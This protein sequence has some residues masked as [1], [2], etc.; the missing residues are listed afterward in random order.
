MLAIIGAHHVVCHAATIAVPSTSNIFGAGHSGAAATPSP[1]GP[2]PGPAPDGGT[3]PPSVSIAGISTVGFAASGT[4][5]FG[6]GTGGH[7]PDG[8]P[9]S[10]YD[11]SSYNGIAG[12][13]GNTGTALYGVFTGAVEP[14]D[15]A[16]AKLNFD[17]NTSFASLSP[18]L[19]QIFFIG[20]GKTGTGAGATQQFAVPSGATTLY[21]GLADGYPVGP[22]GSYLVGGYNDNTGSFLVDVIVPEPSSIALSAF[23]LIGL[24]SAAWRRRH[25]V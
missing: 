2:S 22:G 20:D 12:Y 19:N 13:F 3:A 5:D 16:P 9:T 11:F 24:A 6:G 1:G 18:A 21:L 7:A 23:A 4:V 15:P 14:A 10:S 17:G 25:N 8:Y